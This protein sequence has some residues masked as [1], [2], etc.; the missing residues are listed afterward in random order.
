MQINKDALAPVASTGTGTGYCQKLIQ[1]RSDIDQIEADVHPHCASEA[2]DIE[3][4]S[5]ISTAISM[6]RS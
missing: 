4:A 2:T 1:Q 6:G 5:W 3:E